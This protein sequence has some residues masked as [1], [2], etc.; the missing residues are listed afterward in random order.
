MPAT[1]K[2]I[3][4]GL[5]PPLLVDAYLD[6]FRAV[7]Y[8]GEYA[9]WAEASARGT[10]YDA[11]NILRQVTEAARAVRDGKAAFERDGVLFQD[12]AYNWPLMTCLLREA[13]K[14]DGELRV[15]DFG[16]SLASIYFQHRALLR[17]VAA[18]R[19]AVV[20]QAMFVE[21]GRREFTS[22]ELSFHATADEA[23]AAIRPT[24]A[25]FSGVLAWIEDP[26]AV[27]DTVIRARLPAIIIDRTPLT[28]LERDVAKVQHVP[29]SIYRASYPCW[30][31]SR[32]RFLAH[33]EGR[34]TLRA[35]LPQHD[36]HVKGTDFG[37]LYFE[38]VG[39]DGGR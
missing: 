8:T 13:A 33:F 20:E 36:P 7:R 14:H 28:P 19:W 11:P 18:I 12:P 6:R 38:Q 16:G 22:D 9:T 4:R 1:W 2:K 37:G 10:G 27:L 24:V 34:Y 32:R 31:L 26:H 5:T 29:A 35:E 17:D 3:V 39:K 21:A 23:I 30:F 25:L 15:L